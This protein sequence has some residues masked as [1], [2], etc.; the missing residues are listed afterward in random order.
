MKW[1]KVGEQ[2]SPGGCRAKKKEPA[3]LQAPFWVLLFF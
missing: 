3:G 1:R 2:F